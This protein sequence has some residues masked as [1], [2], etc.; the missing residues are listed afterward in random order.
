MS[1]TNNE[2]RLGI[3]DEVKQGRLEAEAEIYKKRKTLTPRENSRLLSRKDKW[4][5]FK[6]YYM[7]PLL[8]VIAFVILSIFV[9]ISIFEKKEDEELYIGYLDCLYNEE[10]AET[11]LKAFVDS[12]GE[13]YSANDYAAESFFSTWLDNEWLSDYVERGVLDVL[14]MDEQLY[15][16][17]AV[18]GILVDLSEYMDEETYSA[19]FAYAPNQEGEE[20]ATAFICN[21]IP[22]YSTETG[23]EVPAYL[24]VLKKSSRI[25]R[26]VGYLKFASDYQYKDDLSI[27]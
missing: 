6:D 16:A 4:Y 20:T 8:V 26:A 11:A 14:I 23:K 18:K 5:Y 3:A 13:E 25:D 15:R 24:A 22:I 7:K 12:I 19:H 27:K 17:Y 9:G 10:A 1:E 2:N 21:S